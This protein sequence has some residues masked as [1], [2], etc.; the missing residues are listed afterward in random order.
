MKKVAIYISFSLFVGNL[1]F[2]AEK[3][4]TSTNIFNIADFAKNGLLIPIPIR[5]IITNIIIKY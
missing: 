5:D 4:V 2:S 1:S 3:E